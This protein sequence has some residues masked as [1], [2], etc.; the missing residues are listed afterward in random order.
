[1]EAAL[2]LA[3]IPFGRDGV[4]SVRISRCDTTKD[5]VKRCGAWAGKLGIR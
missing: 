2:P 3:A 4:V 5:G 1:V